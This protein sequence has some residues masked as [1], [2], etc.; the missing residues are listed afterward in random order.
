MVE[1]LNNNS[2]ME[3]KKELIKIGKFDYRGIYKFIPQREPFLM[4]DSVLKLDLKKKE[5]VCRKCVSSN[6]WYLAGHFPDNH[7]M[8]GVLLIESM[9]Q[10]ASIIGEALTLEKDG[11]I[12]FTGVEECNFLGIVI[13]GD[14]LNITAKITNIK[15]SAIFGECKV[16][17]DGKVIANCKLKAFK[18]K[19]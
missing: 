19:I 13:A 15:L 10:A 2:L 4:L 18:K 9:A 8:P 17:K 7:I 11:K 12:L 6:E 5:V 16:E 3:Q 14:V 1:I